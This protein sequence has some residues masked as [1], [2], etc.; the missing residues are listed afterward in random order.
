VRE[1]SPA[2]Y[3]IPMRVREAIP[4]ERSASVP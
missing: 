3:V 1:E 2:G 4:I